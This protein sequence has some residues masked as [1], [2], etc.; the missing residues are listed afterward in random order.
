LNF[1]GNFKMIFVCFSF[2][3][4]AKN[5]KKVYNTLWNIPINYIL[6]NGF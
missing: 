3:F 5:R 1:F 2:F 6:F 4:G